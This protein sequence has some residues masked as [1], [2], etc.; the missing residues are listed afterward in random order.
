MDSTMFME[1]TP[2]GSILTSDGERS[3]RQQGFLSA[4]LHVHSIYSDDVLSVPEFYPELLYRKAWNQNLDYITITDHDTMDAYDAIG[5]ERERLVTGVELSLLDPIRVG[6]TLHI[7]VYTLKKSQFLE[8]RRIA[9]LDRNLETFIH[10]LRD[11]NL[12]YVFNHPFWFEQGERPNYQ[13]VEEIIELFPVVEYNM[14]RVRK[15]NLLVLWLAA[16]YNKGIIATTDTHI[17]KIGQSYTMSQ[18]SSFL[19]F[20][21]NIQNRKSWIAPQDLNLANLNSEIV[22]W[23][24]LLFDYENVLEGRTRFTGIHVVDRGIRFLADHAMRNAGAED[25]WFCDLFETVLRK[26]VHTGFFSSL[27]LFQPN[28]NA[29]SIRKL[30]EV[31][32]FRLDSVVHN[33][34][35]INRRESYYC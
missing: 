24:D 6:H 3:L 31:P 29:G 5:W 19:E 1:A 17:G 10:Y 12:P 13:I 27:Y 32:P 30:L 33:Y 4:D 21:Q 2:L 9:R 8:L 25:S 16:K 28:Q 11:Q 20:F 7:N 15:K 22:G 26:I 23:L 14:K 35:D 34:N 18:G